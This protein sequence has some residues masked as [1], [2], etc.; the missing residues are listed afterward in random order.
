MK[1]RNKIIFLLIIGVILLSFF[2]GE[3]LQAEQADRTL[4][5]EY[6]VSDTIT[7]RLYSDGALEIE[8]SGI[9]GEDW[10]GYSHVPWYSQR[11]SIT[12]V[13]VSE[14][15]TT[16]GPY[17]FRNC[18]NLTTI[19]LPAGIT[20]IE[21]YAFY[22]C[23]A[24][25]EIEFPSKMEI[26]GQYAFQNCDSLI[27]ILL[28]DALTEIGSN[29]FYDCDG[30][31]EVTLPDNLTDLGEAVFY[32]C[33]GLKKVT[34]PESVTVLSR[35]CFY[36]CGQLSEVVLPEKLT[37]IE[38]RAFY[39]CSSLGAIVL[40][41]TVT[42]L[43]SN[44][45]QNCGSLS[46]VRIPA[47]VTQVGSSGAFSGCGKLAKVIFG[48]GM[49]K[50]P[51]YICYGMTGLTTV[52]Y[53]KG[54]EGEETRLTSIGQY[55]FYNCSSLSEI[56]L[57]NGLIN[58]GNYVFY[59]C[60]SLVEIMLP[61]SV[62]TLGN[63]AFRNC[64]AM[65][66]ISFG[67]QIQSVGTNA[68]SV[69]AETDTMVRGGNTVT[70]SYNWEGSH[71]NI[72]KMIESWRAGDQVE[73]ALFANGLLVVRGSGA[74]DSWMEDTVPWKEYLPGISGVDIGEGITTA[75]SWML[76]GS[77]IS[78][79]TLPKSLTWVEQ[80][81]FR[82]CESL[83]HIVFEGEVSKIEEGGF[84]LEEKKDTL[85]QGGFP[86]GYNWLAE[87]RRASLTGKAYPLTR[88]TSAVEMN[89][90]LYIVGT[91]SMPDYSSGSVPWK[92]ET[93]T[94][95]V[96]ED[97]VTRIGNNSFYEQTALQSVAIGEKVREIGSSVFQGCSNLV[98]MVIPENIRSIGENCFR[99]CTALKSVTLPENLSSLGE[100]TFYGCTFLSDVNFDE[101][102][103]TEIPISCFY[104]CVSMK[105][106]VIPSTVKSIG[107]NAFSGC[108]EINTLRFEEG[109]EEIGYGAFKGCKITSI[110]IPRSL[111]AVAANSEGGP[112]AGCTMLT[113]ATFADTMRTIPASLFEGASSLQKV[114]LPDTVSGI[115]SKAFRECTS[116]T[117]IALPESMY[118]IGDHAFYGCTALI[119][120]RWNVYTQIIGDYAFCGCTALTEAELPDSITTM[121][122]YT[123]ADCSNLKSITLGENLEAVPS[124]CFEGTSIEEIVLPYKV[125]KINT[126]AFINNEKLKKITIPA[127]TST[128]S[129]SAFDQE[130]MTVYGQKGSQAEI[131]ALNKG[132]AFVTGIGA[133]TLSLSRAEADLAVGEEAFLEVTFSPV[134]M[135]Q[136]IVWTSADSSVAAVQ[137]DS[138]DPSKAIVIGKAAGETDVTVQIGTI[139]KTCHISVGN[140]ITGLKVNPSYVYFSNAEQSRKLSVSITPS[141]AEEQKLVW[142][143]SDRN[144]AVVNEDG[145]VTPIGNGSA[146]ITVSTEDGRVSAYCFVT[147][148]MEV[149][150][151]GINIQEE[152][153][154][155][156][157]DKRQLTAVLL[158]EN[159]TS[160]EIQ[161]SS[162]NESIVT[163]D[164]Q[165]RLT[166]VSEGTAVITAESANGTFKDTCQVHVKFVQ[167]PVQ[168]IVL[169]QETITFNELGET[170]VLG[171]EIIPANADVREIIYSSEN[172]SVAEVDQ[173]GVITAVGGGSTTI[174]AEMKDGSASARCRV[175]VNRLIRAMELNPSQMTLTVDEERRITAEIIPIDA[176]NQELLWYSS[177]R[178]VATV[179][180]KG[181]VM[182][183]GKGT[184]YIRCRAEDGS[185]QSAS[186]LVTVRSATDQDTPEPDKPV[187]PDISENPNPPEKPEPPAGSE[188]TDASADLEDQTNQ[189]KPTN[190][191][192]SGSADSVGGSEHSDLAQ[193]GSFAS[194]QN[195]NVHAQ[196][197][198]KQKIIS[199]SK[200]KLKK[201][202]TKKKSMIVEWKKVQCQGY[203][204][205]YS[206]KK[207][208]TKT[209]MKKV[210]SARKTKV[211]L[212]NL[213]RNKKYYVRIRAYTIYDGEMY[214]G[215]WSKV[216]KIRI[217]G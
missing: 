127:Y 89:D 83:A 154:L 190:P 81:A 189:E 63:S 196:D 113:E 27:A 206:L 19:K 72:I 199:V 200:V 186:C 214:F 153:I 208:F 23:S 61:E 43:E 32:D 40:P 50:I 66:Y 202:Q 11:T 178:N 17:A 187:D 35:N 106:A 216:K 175:T 105:R 110:R 85:A 4:Q 68:F 185:N 121:G 125:K 20:R 96:I 194:G 95:A 215:S 36:S 135:T 188:D 156:T 123:F 14:N 73:A 38:Y 114:T 53:E 41:E 51:D 112:F 62:T 180:D 117:A 161:W 116:L 171:T 18:S 184:A 45:F 22:G 99:G 131:L 120:I 76:A 140:Y 69:S 205:Q 100:S 3:N 6:A 181:N 165:G 176:L 39:N 103:V 158:P 122:K 34:L 193:N 86:L 37:T 33:D 170:A 70:E 145:L 26:I 9:M 59:N 31:S 15:I 101:T 48:Y 97:G 7:A 13:S 118:E 5:N 204:I 90:V 137:V 217:K 84:A 92:E 167:I 182:A 109:V 152:E 210:T 75:G 146:R 133:E 119:S 179:D 126:Y 78:F 94:G 57:P 160:K 77:N 183:V 91:G 151:T 82:N 212:K 67:S 107:N 79:L 55:A 60:K 25:S 197:N 139:A 129:E 21:D 134:N 138:A 102:A 155:I 203:Q 162:S 159:A 148:E 173:Q 47:A 124:Y 108:S 141:K 211:K 65:D 16:V 198:E 164:A 58:L 150:V 24:L 87:N 207:K 143:S 56:T 52:E 144:V 2:S 130:S 169:E 54:S 12:T 201:I 209:K 191:Q 166:P 98:D 192:P 177:N 111:K 128:I 195:E 64:D 149:P 30:L 88:R 213:K 74:M 136:E 71:R 8:G 163:V 49:E 46:E 157:N 172:P 93:L 147:V 44:A 10:T 174:I 28:P 104:G 80:N 29:A 142:A 42:T 132:Y 1:K 168:E 115:G